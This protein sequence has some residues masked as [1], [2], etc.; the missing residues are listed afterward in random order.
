M[1][2]QGPQGRGRGVKEK[3]EVGTEQRVEPCG[4]RPRARGWLWWV[5]TV[6][7]TQPAHTSLLNVCPQSCERVSFCCWKTPRQKC[8]VKQPRE[9][10]IMSIS[11]P[12]CCVLA[13]FSRKQIPGQG[14]RRGCSRGTRR[15]GEEGEARKG[16]LSPT[17]GLLR[18]AVRSALVV[19]GRG[20]KEVYLPGSIISCFLWF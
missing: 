1:P 17:H 16:D 6:G 13:R 2:P 18:K 8:F 5:L 15:Q 12:K 10:E 7:R 14:W 4:H 11:Q 3:G 20:K 9:T 19:H